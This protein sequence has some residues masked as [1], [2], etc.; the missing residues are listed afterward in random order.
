MT[1][2][3]KLIARSNDASAVIRKAEDGKIFLDF[4]PSVFNQTSKLIREYGEV[5]YEI[6]APAAFD[7]VLADPG[8]N[9]L[10]TVD[11]DR[12]QMLGRNKSNTLT[13]VTDAKGLKATVEMPDTNLGRDMS[14][15]IARG[16]YF[17]C[18]FIYTIGENGVQYDR[19]GDIPIRTITSIQ[20]LYDVSI[21]IDGAFA[22]TTIS[23]RALDFMPEV[24]TPTK[25]QTEVIARE[26]EYDILQKQLNLKLKNK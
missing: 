1:T 7:R 19:S 11:H 16:D 14:V 2:K 5:F 18:S 4:Y 20:D 25:D 6:I 12:D 3:I 9:C 23:K 10:A 26:I 15:L 22:N 8:L 21:V 24:E 13:L 17:E